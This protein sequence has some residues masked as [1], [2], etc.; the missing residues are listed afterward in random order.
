VIRTFLRIGLLGGLAFTSTGEDFGFS[1][2]FFIRADRRGGRGG[3]NRAGPAAGAASPCSCGSGEDDAPR[4]G[5][6]FAATGATSE[7]SPPIE[8]C[9]VVDV[10][11]DD[12][13]FTE[14]P[15]I[16]DKCRDVESEKNAGW[17]IYRAKRSKA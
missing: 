6:R 2:T 9:Q 1:A 13:D 17:F 4:S 12:D 10:T 3:W 7:K 14:V 5:L 8:G 11:K 15:R 16:L